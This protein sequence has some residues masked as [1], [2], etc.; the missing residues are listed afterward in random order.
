MTG[1]AG[2]LTD[3]APKVAAQQEIVLEG[4]HIL[5]ETV[6]PARHIGRALAKVVAEGGIG[7]TVCYGPPPACA[8]CLRVARVAASVSEVPANYRAVYPSCPAEAVSVSR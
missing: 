5:T 1:R 3:L 8:W 6:R 4:V 2:L 7:S